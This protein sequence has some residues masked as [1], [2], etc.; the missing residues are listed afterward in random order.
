MKYQNKPWVIK[1]WLISHYNKY[2]LINWYKIIFFHHYMGIYVHI[3][4]II[5]IIVMSVI[6]IVIIV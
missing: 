5:V 3:I 4:I 2:K 6:I 1:K